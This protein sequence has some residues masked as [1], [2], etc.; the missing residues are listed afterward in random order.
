VTV[1]VSGGDLDQAEVRLPEMFPLPA[2]ENARFADIGTFSFG[3]SASGTES[4]A[5]F[6]VTQL[7]WNGRSAEVGS[8]P[9]SKG[10]WRAAWEYMNDELPALAKMVAL[11]CRH[12]AATRAAALLTA[13]DR[14]ALEGEGKLDVLPNCVLLGGYGFEDGVFPGDR[15]DIYFTRRGIWMSKAGGYRPYLRR[16]YES[17]RA[18]I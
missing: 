9:V 18:R 8:W 11:A 1:A 10:G 15:V 3:W 17:A 13:E 4:D 7:R 6:V 12:S 16:P 14:Q 2:P 5:R